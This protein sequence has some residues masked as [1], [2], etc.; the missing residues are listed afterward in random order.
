MPRIYVTGTDTDVGKTRVTAALARALHEAGEPTTIVKLVQTGLGPYEP[1]DA[2]IAAAL[3]GCDA[4]EY[5]RLPKP[6]DPW[7]AARA[8]GEEPERASALAARLCALPGSVVVEGS[9]GAA[10]PLN[11]RETI[12]DVAREAAL[13]AVVV[14]G[15]RLGCISHARL[16]VEYLVHR[17]IPLLGLV[18][19]ERTALDD[20]AY[21]GE[22]EDALRNWGAMLGT[23]PFEVDAAASVRRA[24]DCFSSLGKSP[25]R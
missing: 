6:A 8:A 20:R 2:Q 25:D 18:L 10:V 22:V 7:N 1:G 23:I 21:P 13:E 16:T 24:A 4:V 3:A 5:R 17:G 19:C 15:L 9:G 12:T 11:E 14:V